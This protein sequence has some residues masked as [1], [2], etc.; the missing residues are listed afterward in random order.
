MSNSPIDRAFNEWLEHKTLSKTLTESLQANRYSIEVNYRTKIDEVHD[1]FAKLCLGYISAGM[2]NCGYHVK[3]LFTSKPFR[4]SVSTRNWDDGEWVGLA[5]F[6]HNANKFVVAKGTYNKDRKTVSIH[7][8][9]KCQGVSAAE[10]VKELRNLM[11]ELKRTP[12][13]GSNTLEPAQLKR[14][15]KPTHL[16]KLK[17]VSGPFKPKKAI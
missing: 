9:K 15:P 17:K 10:V 14:G 11:E 13:K 7:S 12:P 4:I 1:A 8:S 2:K 16:K 5:V 3:V 6:D